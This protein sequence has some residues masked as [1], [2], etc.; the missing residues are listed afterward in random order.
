MADYERLMRL[1]AL[2]FVI[3]VFATIIE[4]ISIKFVLKRSYDWR[5]AL[6]S[7]GVMAGRII[8][9][10]IVPIA[11]AMPGAIW[12]YQHRIADL[13]QYGVW[14]Y[15]ILFFGLEF[16][17][18]WW[19]RVGHRSRWF[20]ISHSVHHT[21]NELNMTASFR[22]GWT[23]RIM[24][25][26]V[27]FTPLVL[28]GFDPQVVFAM[29]S[30]CLGFQFWLHADWIPKLGFLEG[31]INTPSAHRVHHASNLE[32][33][34]CNYGGVLTIYDRMFGSYKPELDELPVRYG[35][36]VPIYSYNP[37]K[38]IFYPFAPLVRDVLSARSAREVIGYI[39]GPP[40]WRPDGQGS[41]TEDLRRASDA[42]ADI[43]QLK[44]APEPAE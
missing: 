8:S 14:S 35:L 38:L 20:W 29:Y 6:A 43:P 24:A 2:L 10:L 5:A 28:V 23:Q 4:A 21:P 40:G 13:S 32:Y 15:V 37:L 33:L 31:T 7:Y 42:P 41:T 22:V 30:F 11:I 18:Y 19:H 36:V 44:P 9:D 39:F 1:A 3:G 17:Y 25:T 26:Y 12:F 27:I 34:D 16:V